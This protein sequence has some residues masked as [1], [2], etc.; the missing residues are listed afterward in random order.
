M[1]TIAHICA[2][3]NDRT[4]LHDICLNVRAGEI[5]GLIG[6]N[7]AGK[8]TLLRVIGGTLR[9]TTGVV[10][11]DDLDLLRL[12]V[13]ERAKRIAVVPQQAHMPGGFSVAEVVLM[14]RTPHLPRF[15][16]ERAHD[17]QI[18]RDAMERT[19]TWPLVRRRISEL[20]GG[21]QQRVVIARAL[22]QEPQ[23]LLLDEATAHLDLKHQAAI[24][25]LI[26]KLA[27]SG[28]IVLVAMHDLNLAALYTDRLALL[29]QGRLLVCDVPPVVLTP[30]WLRCAYDV[31][32]VVSSHPLYHTPLV[33][34]V[35]DEEGEHQ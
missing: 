22:T 34:M 25:Q 3:Y 8:S 32:V 33:A 1:L 11:L 15:G 7:G 21:E 9:P 20:S 4:V 10:N 24:L 5:V 28:L 29:H 23:V 12:S 19:A 17:Y 26:R 14:G 16:W 18:A 27:R 31:A 6:P 2:G 13:T 30:E 35:I